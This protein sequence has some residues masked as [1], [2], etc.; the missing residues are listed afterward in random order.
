MKIKV[1]FGLLLLLSACNTFSTSDTVTEFE[2]ISTPYQIESNNSIDNE[3]IYPLNSESQEDPII[4]N[5]PETI[6]VPL[7]DEMKGIVVGKLLSNE[8]ETP[9]INGNLFL[10]SYLLP[11]EAFDSPPLLIS[12]SIDED[13]VALRSQDGTFLFDG[14]EPGKYGLIIWSPASFYQIFEPDSQTPII[15]EVTS[16]QIT[17]L[18]TLFVP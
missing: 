6:K 13:P 11:N 15:V 2:N 14:I 1:L 12:V 17:N 10:V 8:G 4:E 16:N 3:L 7:P 5:L 18:G 9:Y